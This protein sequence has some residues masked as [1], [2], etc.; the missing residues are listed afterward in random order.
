MKEWKN[1]RKEEWKNGRKE[2]R[3]DGRMEK[4]K[5]GRNELEIKDIHSNK[6]LTKAL[7]TE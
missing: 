5:K 6:V 3:K 4:W 1:G 7:V 2:D